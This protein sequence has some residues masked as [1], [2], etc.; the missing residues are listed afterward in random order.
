MG[1]VRGEAWE[2]SFFRDRVN[3]GQEVVSHLQGGG[4]L[5]LYHIWVED[6]LEEGSNSTLGQ[7]LE[8]GSNLQGQEGLEEGSIFTCDRIKEGLEECSN[9]LLRRERRN[10]TGDHFLNK[11]II[12]IKIIKID[13]IIY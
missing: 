3:E 2:G 1:K 4:K 11:I 5:K 12:I 13:W 8:E 7:G 6:G 10:H 9:F